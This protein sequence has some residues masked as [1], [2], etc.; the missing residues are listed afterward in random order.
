M[1]ACKHVNERLVRI[2]VDK[3]V[4]VNKADRYGN[5]PLILASYYNNENIVNYLIEKGA[6]V[7]KE[8]IYGNTALLEACKE[9]HETIIQ[10]L[11][12]NGAEVNIENKDNDTPLLIACKYDHIPLL[13]YFIEKGAYI[14]REDRSMHTV[15]EYLTIANNKNL[16]EILNEKLKK[17]N[18][19]E[20]PPLHRPCRDDNEHWVKEFITAIGKEEINALDSFGYNPLTIACKKWQ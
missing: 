10:R 14:H 3:G 17:L 18:N 13:D 7:H 8:N 2:L 5:T 4:D 6:D 16:I 1:K 9:K 15:M 11:I 20:D 19:P 12:E